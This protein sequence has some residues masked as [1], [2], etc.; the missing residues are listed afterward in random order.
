MLKSQENQRQENQR[1]EKEEDEKENENLEKWRS[2]KGRSALVEGERRM[3]EHRENY[4]GGQAN[5]CG[6][7]SEQRSTS[8]CHDRM[9]MNTAAPIIR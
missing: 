3:S 4:R 5:F 2:N 7:G 8:T 9:N 1:Q 6:N